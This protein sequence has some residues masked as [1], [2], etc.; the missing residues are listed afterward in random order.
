MKC[1]FR[2]HG[3]RPGL[4]HLLLSPELL[5]SGH[6]IDSCLKKYLMNLARIAR[7]MVESVEILIEE[8]SRV[9]YANSTVS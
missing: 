7:I 9:C 8:E 5:C 6:N 4:P 3:Q 1:S 2:G